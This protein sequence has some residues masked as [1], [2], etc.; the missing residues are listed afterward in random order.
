M[1][2]ATSDLLAK[3]HSWFSSGPQWRTAWD[4]HPGPSTVTQKS[5][6]LS[7]ALRGEPGSRKGCWALPPG[8]YSPRGEVHEQ[9]SWHG[10][11]A[12][13]K[14]VQIQCGPGKRAARAVSDPGKDPAHTD[15]DRERKSRRFNLEDW[16]PLC[17]RAEQ[18]RWSVPRLL[19]VEGAADRAV[20]GQRLGK[21]ACLLSFSEVLSLVLCIQLWWKIRE[22]P[23]KKL[24]GWKEQY[25]KWS[26][27]CASCF[28]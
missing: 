15:G 4:L 9:I 2:W 26:H 18:T 8:A 1:L 14:N 10:T 17:P 22:E 24:K 16:L 20:C 5:P 28:F 12:A 21:P 7:L 19:L 27:S 25:L 3:T 13:W 6:R 23:V 11:D